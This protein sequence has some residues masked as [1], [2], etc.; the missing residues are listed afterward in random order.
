MKTKTAKSKEYY[1]LVRVKPKD[2]KYV[3]GEHR[4]VL[5]FESNE[6]RQGKSAAIIQMNG[7]TTNW[8][9]ENKEEWSPD[10]TI[11]K[12]LCWCH[13]NKQ[14]LLD[15]IYCLN[16]WSTVDKNPSGL[17]GK[18]N[19]TLNN[20]KN[21]KWIAKIC[22]N[23]DYVIVAHGDCNGVDPLV[24]KERKEQLG[25]LLLGCDL[26]HVGELTKK[27]NPRHGRGWN[28]NPLLNVFSF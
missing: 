15:N 26:Y 27:G 3:V 5:K 19:E 24:L 8:I 11:G 1:R 20:A 13:E 17:K 12:V 18:V 9:D 28:S 16:M 7:S 4:Y 21:D 14:V 22:K 10:P 23:V 2:Y 6:L 25:K